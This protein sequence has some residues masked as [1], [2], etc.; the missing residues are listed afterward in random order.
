MLSARVSLKP[1]ME[2]NGRAGIHPM[3]SGCYSY[4]LV[5]SLGYFLPPEGNK[6]KCNC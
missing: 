1:G 5:P 6:V 3:Y 2:W 4:R